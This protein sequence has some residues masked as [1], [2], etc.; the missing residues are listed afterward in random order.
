MVFCQYKYPTDPSKTYEPGGIRDT[1]VFTETG[2]RERLATEYD[3]EI[4]GRV[5]CALLVLLAVLLLL[6]LPLLLLRLLL[7]FFLESII[8]TAVSV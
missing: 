1:S 3:D 2:V 6:F 5:R 4:T 7:L 8:D